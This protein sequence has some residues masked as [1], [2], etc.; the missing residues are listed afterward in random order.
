MENLIKKYNVPG[1][2]YT[3]YPTVPFWEIERHTEANWKQSVKDGFWRSGK[4]ISYISIYHFV[5]AYVPIVG[6]QPESRKT[7]V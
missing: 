7:I 5:K 6:A 1:P 2:R 3:S 4:E